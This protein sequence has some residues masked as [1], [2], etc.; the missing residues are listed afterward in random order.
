LFIVYINTFIANTSVIHAVYIKKEVPEEAAQ[1]G[2]DVVVGAIVGLRVGAGVGL[3]VGAGVGLGVGAGVGFVVGF[4]VG[5]T[6]GCG[7]GD[8]PPVHK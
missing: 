2:M 6:V 3:E 8:V 7:V 1:E 4:G 5:G